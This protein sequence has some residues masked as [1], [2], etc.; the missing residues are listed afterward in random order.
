FSFEAI[1]GPEIASTGTPLYRDLST[2][3]SIGIIEGLRFLF[4]SLG[5]FKDLRRHFRE[6]NIDLVILID[7]QGRN[8]PIGKEAQRAGLKTIYY[9]PPPV[10]IW[11]RWNV[12]KMLPYDLLLC[13]FQ[14][15]AEIYL[16]GGCRA[17]WT[18]HPFS[19]LEKN[20]DRS[21]YK[22]K[23]GLEPG[24]KTVAL[25]PGSRFQEIETLTGVFMK[26]ARLLL[27]WNPDLQF[28]LS[29][30]HPAYRK[31][32]GEWIRRSGVPISLVERQPDDV[33]K[34]SDFLITASGTATLQAAYYSLPMAI[35]YKI[36]W[37]SY[38][39]YRVLVDVR[40]IGLPNLA[41]G[42]EICREFIQRNCN[43]KNLFEYAKSHLENQAVHDK[44]AFELANVREALS[45]PDP[46]GRMAQG[47]L[48]VL[49]G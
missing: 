30:S 10:A 28:V 16:K 23:L 14:N 36:S 44:T 48:G 2:Q 7:G 5:L 20:P 38:W 6:G 29:L 15:D 1:G 11:G 26:T 46:F 40:H 39:I 41:A 27:D 31:E 18:G 34:A 49:E 37:S 32:V 35:C 12:K 13:P 25:F 45:T 8:I 4:S 24:K 33:M 43:P 3:S 17:L 21:A 42:R 22:K 47:I 19:L 9:F